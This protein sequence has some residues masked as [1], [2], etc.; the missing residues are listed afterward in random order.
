MV[1]EDA[2]LPLGGV[3]VGVD[4]GGEDGFVAEHLLDDA[5]VRAVLYQMGGE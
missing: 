4:F 5:Q 2:L 3:N 1:A